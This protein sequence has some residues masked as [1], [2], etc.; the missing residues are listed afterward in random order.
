MNQLTQ[1][2]TP[3]ISPQIG[4]MIVDDHPTLLWGLS[5]LING[6]RSRMKVIGTARNAEEASR[7]IQDAIPDVV[8]LDLDLDGENGLDLL[9]MLLMNRATRVLILTGER[10]Q[11]VLD[12]ALQ[13]GVRGILRKDASAE[14]V[15]RAIEKVHQGE[16]WLDRST[17]GRVFN[18]STEPTATHKPDPDA[19]MCA[20]LTE[21]E[22][23]IIAMVVEGQGASNKVLAEKLFI[24]EHTLR[25]HL[26][27]IYNK[28]DV[29]N[30]LGL[31]VYAVNHQMGVQPQ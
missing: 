8:L 12:Q 22:R 4:V 26:T 28:L 18:E 11:S 21:R 7:Q 23:K 19:E 25:N 6:E 31:Y 9:P 3:H 15:L 29:E 2:N 16:I 5:K 13:K 17:L 30:R 27:S 24:S 14:L 1:K 10:Q 20:S